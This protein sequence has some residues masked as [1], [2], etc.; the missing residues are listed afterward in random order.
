MKIADNH[1]CEECEEI[2]PAVV[3]L[4]EKEDWESRTANIC[5]SCLKKALK[6]LED[7]Q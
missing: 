3:T 6:L 5:E 1:Y 2:K 4:G 7:T